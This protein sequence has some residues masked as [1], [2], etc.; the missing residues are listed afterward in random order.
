LEKTFEYKTMLH[1]KPMD[2]TI[3]DIFIV[4]KLS[5]D[6]KIWDISEIK[7]KVMLIYDGISSIAMPT[8]HT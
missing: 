1:E 7:K 5:H 8:I 2:S 3:F 6:L 4:K